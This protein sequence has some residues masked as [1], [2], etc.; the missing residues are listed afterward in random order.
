M[1]LYIKEERFFN[2]LTW[3][4]PISSGIIVSTLLVE[5]L[6][7]FN[8]HYTSML[9]FSSCS[10][11]QICWKDFFGS[12]FNNVFALFHVAIVSIGFGIQITI[13]VRQRQLE[14][15]QADG[16]MVVRYNKD[17][18]LISKG[19]PQ[20]PCH[21]LWRHN[22]TVLTP[23]ASLSSFILSLT[24]ILLKGYIFFNIG[25]SG[26]PALGEF[27]IFSSV[28]VNFFLYNFI[29]TICSPTLRNSLMDR[30]PC[31]RRE[32]HVVIV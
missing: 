2:C 31:L 25:P 30:I 26:P 6:Y 15:Q 4:Y 9:V 20:P 7:Y 18:A 32:Y 16:N 19:N 28:S 17:G 3:L 21:K 1:L 24:I 5:H 22:R 13:F 14:K 12:V 10:K 11:I 8:E 23:L 29:E 27:L